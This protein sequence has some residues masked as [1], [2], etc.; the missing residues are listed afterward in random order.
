MRNIIAH[1]RSGGIVIVVV[2]D[3][4]SEEAT[5]ASLGHPLYAFPHISQAFA[6]KTLQCLGQINKLNVVAQTEYDG[7]LI[8]V[9]QKPDQE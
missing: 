1:T 8:F 2:P 6:P 3:A 5:F 9:F 4:E 7:L